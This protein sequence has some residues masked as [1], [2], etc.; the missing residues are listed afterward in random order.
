MDWTSQ[1]K[2]RYIRST[3]VRNVSCS[4]TTVAVSTEALVA[5]ATKCRGAVAVTTKRLV[6][7]TLANSVIHLRYLD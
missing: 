7:K 5:M 6:D 4:A 1:T 3:F 2:A